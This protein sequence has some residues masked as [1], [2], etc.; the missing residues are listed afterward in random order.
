MV[1][2]ASTAPVIQNAPS[3]QSTAGCAGSSVGYSVALALPGDA[4]GANPC[5]MT[6]LGSIVKPHHKSAFILPFSL[7]RGLLARAPRYLVTASQLARPN[8]C[9]VSCIRD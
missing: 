9:L 7:N 4:Q 1:R 6:W 3:A 2:C 8:E 5:L